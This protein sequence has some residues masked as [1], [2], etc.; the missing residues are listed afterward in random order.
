MFQEQE[1]PLYNRVRS[2]DESTGGEEKGTSAEGHRS[3]SG[4][5]DDSNPI[6]RNNRDVNRQPMSRVSSRGK[7]KKKKKTA[8]RKRFSVIPSHAQAA[9]STKEVEM[10]SKMG[11][12]FDW[13]L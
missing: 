1:N 4:T 3:T 11:A 12:N 10:A 7:K 9:P 8:R 6:A 2:I 5:E 13:D